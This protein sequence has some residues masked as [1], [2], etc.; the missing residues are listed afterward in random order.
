MDI[1]KEIGPLKEFLK[2]KKSKNKTIGLIPTMGALH[3]GHLALV[4]SS[5]MENDVTVSTIFINPTQFNN[6]VDLDKYPRTFDA[7]I[8]KLK[9][10]G[11]DAVFCPKAE[12][13]YPD[14]PVLSLDFGSLATD[15][16]GKFRPGH[17]SGV[18]LIVSKL[19]NIVNPD[20][21]YFGQKDLQQFFI[22]QRL[23]IDLSF[24]IEL[25]CEPIVR[26]SSGLAMSS[27][28]MRLSQS[29]KSDASMIYKSLRRAEDAIRREVKFAEIK[30]ELSR[31][32]DQNGVHL[33][34]FELVD[35]ERMAII[36]DYSSSSKL[37]LC[38][39]AFVEEVRL[40]D[41]LIISLD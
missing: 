40:I 6:S 9:A 34:Y 15:M 2:D 32:L 38:I 24:D 18:G 14:K 4:N 13:V 37:A 7:D 31:F 5:K 10:S 36:N 19:F 16:E 23:V 35:A 17:F 26:E 3:E 25:R 39:A 29:G 21:A 12:E 22:I 1:F 11:C 33:E 27:R 8:E 30:K 20:R 41:N 28:N